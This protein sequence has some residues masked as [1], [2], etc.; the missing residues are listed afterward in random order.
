[1]ISLALSVLAGVPSDKKSPTP[2]EEEKETKETKE[3]TKRLK[4]AVKVLPELINIRPEEKERVSSQ[5]KDIYQKMGQVISKERNKDVREEIEKNK[6]IPSD[7]RALLLPFS[8][9]QPFL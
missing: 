5:L 8:A 1:M 9:F 4:T 3:E 2:S 6:S 7:T